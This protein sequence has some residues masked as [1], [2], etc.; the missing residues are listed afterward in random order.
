MADN[1][2]Q[3]LSALLAE[4]YETLG[5]VGEN[6]FGASAAMISCITDLEDVLDSEA[7]CE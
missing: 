2:R 6:D 3:R 1:L 7:V 5:V 4:W